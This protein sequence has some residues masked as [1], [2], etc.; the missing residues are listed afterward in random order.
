M[1]NI[2][3]TLLTS[4]SQAS[5]KLYAG[6]ECEIVD[7]LN[8][9]DRTTNRIQDIRSDLSTLQTHKYTTVDGEYKT[10]MIKKLVYDVSPT[11]GSDI[12]WMPPATKET[13]TPLPNVGDR[14]PRQK[15]AAWLPPSGPSG[16][17][18]VITSESGVKRHL[19]LSNKGQITWFRKDKNNG[20]MTI[21][22]READ[23]ANTKLSLQINNTASTVNLTK[24]KITDNNKIETTTENI[25]S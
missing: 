3:I 21:E 10:E 12:F 7:T 17:T 6:P 25:F 2:L 16:L 1:Y 23:D 22:E 14:Q 20:G 9:R 13:T 8:V 15:P 5:I 19:R 4:S 24:T 18:M 11:R